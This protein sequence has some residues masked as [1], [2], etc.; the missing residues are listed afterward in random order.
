MHPILI[1]IGSYA[2]SSYGFLF[3]TGA[4]IGILLAFRKAKR[5]ELT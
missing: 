4:L 3:A 1:H 2:Q 5:E